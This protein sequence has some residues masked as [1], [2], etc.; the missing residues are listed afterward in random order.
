MAKTNIIADLANYVPTKD[1]HNIIEEKVKN[2]IANVA[3]VMSLIDDNFNADEAAEL[4]RRMFLAIK[5]N[6]PTKVTRKLREYKRGES[7]DD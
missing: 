1:K 5:S 7:I 4:N 6:D 2:A 3:N